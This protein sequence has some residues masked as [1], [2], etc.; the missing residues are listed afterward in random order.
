M[1]KSIFGSLWAGLSGPLRIRSKFKILFL[2]A[3]FGLSL[4]SQA[5][6]DCATNVGRFVD[7]HGQVETQVADGDAWLNASFD[8][9]LCEGSS[10]RVGAQSRAAISLINDA[11]LRLDENTTMR[12]VNIVE[13][14]EEQSLLDILKGALHS[15]SRK[16]KKLMVNS[17]YL[18]GS[19]EGTEFVFRVTDDQSELTVFEGTVVAAN[20]QGDSSVTTGESVV[21]EQGEAPTKR[22]LV[23]PRDQVT[24][25]LYYPSI[26]ISGEQSGDPQIIEIATL[27]ESGR[28]NQAREKLSPLLATD[29]GLAYA[30]S[31]V[32]NVALNETEQ[33][34]EDGVRAVELAPSTPSFIALSYAQQSNLDLESARAT[35]QQANQADPD[36]ALVLA[37]LAELNLMLGNRSEAVDLAQQA[38]SINSGLDNPQVV[39]GFAALALNDHATA[40]TAFE[41][42]ISLNS[43][44]PLS[45]LGLGLSKISAGDL[46]AGRKDIEAA[47]ALDS[48]NAVFRAYLGKSY[49]EEKRSNL[50]EDQYEIA[51]SLDPNDP[52]A[53]LYSGILKQTEN[54]PVE[55]LEDIEQSIALND[56][57]AVY[58]SRLL[59]D[60]DRAARGTSIA[61]AYSDLGFNQLATNE[62]S[63]SL[64]LDPSNASAHRFLSDSYKKEGRTEIGRVS[65]LFQAQMLQD[66]NLTPIQPSLAASNLNLVT[67]GGPAQTGFNE[68]TPLFQRNQSQLDTSLQAGSNDLAAG[69]VV[70]TGVF[71]NFSI[72]AGVMS[73]DNDGWR[74]NNEVEQDLGN[75]FIQYA[76]NDKFSLQAEF[77]ERET[78]QGDLAFNFSE[79]SQF[80]DFFIDTEQSV[81]R[82]GAKYKPSIQST[83]LVS[84]IENSLEED[85]VQGFEPQRLVDAPDPLPS[86]PFPP[87]TPNPVTD[88]VGEASPDTEGDQLELQYIFDTTNYNIITGVSEIDNDITE[89]ASITFTSSDGVTPVLAPLLFGDIG[90]YGTTSYSPSPIS[91]SGDQEQSHAYIYYNRSF[92]Q[93]LDITI[94]VSRDE[95]EDENFEL[96][97]NYPKFGLKWGFTDNAQLRL[98]AFETFK[99]LLANNRT[100]EPSQIAGF[101]QFFDDFD[102][103]ESSR[104][105]IGLDW[106]AAPD[107]KM[108]FEFTERDLDVPFFNATANETQF[109]DKEESMHK[110]SLYY[111]LAK[112]W[113]FVAELLYDKHESEEG[114]FT[115]G[116]Q[117]PVSVTT[118]TIPLTVN[119]FNPNGFFASIKGSYVDQ[120]VDRS[121]L[122]QSDPTLSTPL[123][124]PLENQGEDDFFVVDLV[125]GYRLPKRQG[126]LSFGVLNV[127]DEDFLYQDDSYR[128]KSVAVTSPYFPE[129]V[130]VGQLTLHF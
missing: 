31:S 66:V 102:G 50:G 80:Y 49:F 109:E 56:N 89:E 129:R 25:G 93:D 86:P 47:V 14:E 76:V 61:R 74:D 72:S 70:Y 27:L 10:I 48:N 84:Y 12:L 37:R 44:N 105:G 116:S 2:I 128:E 79:D 122:D 73:Y 88:I 83:F 108:S 32:I 85:T 87:A 99:P 41:T 11:V 119:Y 43:S 110:I 71:N 90:A 45:Y 77:F 62:A 94:G 51:K 92:S 15:F 123:V 82:V 54:R 106:T 107:V 124:T 3:L 7:I 98:A 115:V 100:L 35:L 42:A 38:A 22:V 63:K 103:T 81:S 104:A 26:L 121:D 64:I 52:T 58:R 65:E 91:Q 6:A 16:P 67:L 46:T 75:I 36:S 111:I 95:Y 29:N 112:N 60:Q 117:T 69:E 20:D 130:I 19:I 8:T 96:S 113:S 24:W 30:L 23:N 114:F 21:A 55:A 17:A 9:E 127:F 68:F 28:V 125:A 39:L 97:E 53:Y 40:G 34:L 59:L 1:K 18:N 126:I 78:H 4:T 33:A 120:E 57:R 101:N 118:K 5:R 13:E